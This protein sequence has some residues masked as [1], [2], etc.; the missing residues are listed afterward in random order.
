M[1]PDIGYFFL[2]KTELFKSQTKFGD[3]ESLRRHGHIAP[4]EVEDALVRVQVEPDDVED[5]GV[6]IL[7]DCEVVG[8]QREDDELGPLLSAHV[9]FSIVRTERMSTTDATALSVVVGDHNEGFH[10]DALLHCN[11]DGERIV[12]RVELNTETLKS[13]LGKSPPL[14][15]IKWVIFRGGARVGLWRRRVCIGNRRFR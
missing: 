9:H 7:C 10:P 11:D 14:V 1:I 5:V 15:E 4:D 12:C 6:A 3:D 8:R 13:A 2:P